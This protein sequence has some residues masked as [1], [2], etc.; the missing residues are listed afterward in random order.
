[1]ITIA[2]VED[3]EKLNYIVSARLREQ[4]YDVRSCPNPIK[5]FDIMEQ[6]KIDLIVSDIMMPEMDG[7]EFAEQV[8]RS[9]QQIPILYMTAKDDIASK[10][11]GFDLGIDDYMV[12]PIDL[13]ELV[14][15]VEALFR[16]AKIAASQ[17]LTVGRLTL[18][19]EET[20]AYYCGEELPLTV[21]EF[22]ILFKMLSY[23]KKTFTR[24]Q[25]MDEFWGFDSESGPRTVDVSITK[26]REKIS[27]CREV[28]I[29]TVRGL[30]YKAVLHNEN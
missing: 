8:R 28:E 30:G 29:V 17:E 22:Q 13:S 6:E 14:M 2:V 16:R 11:R 15:R 23:P 20:T 1:M 19:E 18:K 4:G 26:L 7:F 24:A 9:D 27:S 12:K 25:L 5:A 3:D 21:R 10:K